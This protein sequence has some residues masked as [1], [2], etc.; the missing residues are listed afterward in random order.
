MQRFLYGVIFFILLITGL[1]GTGWAITDGIKLYKV[2]DVSVWAIADSI[3]ER[4]VL[5]FSG[6]PVEII[7]EYM[8]LG[9]VPSS[10]MVFVLQTDANIIL[11]DAGLGGNAGYALVGLEE[12]GF[13]PADI[14]VVLLTHFH[15]D[16][17][18]GLLNESGQKVFPNAKILSSRAEQSY[19]LDYDTMLANPEKLSGFEA[20]RKLAEVY[21]E[22]F[23]A[24]DFNK[25]ILPGIKALNASGY[26]PGHTA[27]LME[28][29][30]EKLLLW[31][32]LVHAAALQ[33]PHPEINSVYDM[34][35][36][37]SRETRLSFMEMAATENMLIGGSHLPFPGLGKIAKIGDRSYKY[38]TVK[39]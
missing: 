24:F 33:F 26:T 15:G 21:G 13:K 5:A 32:D 30:G 39:H 14:D 37:K 16:H 1:A 34:I 18:G 22:K 7:A 12:A 36:D 6:N 11:V 9:K 28:S 8:P 20:A 3:V 31:G 29:K 27:F 35:P 23:L 10:I 25:N 38:I 17:I 4:D 2:G 19:W